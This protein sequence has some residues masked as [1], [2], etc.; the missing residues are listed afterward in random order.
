MKR[1]ILITL[2]FNSFLLFSQDRLP[3][4]VTYTYNVNNTNRLTDFTNKTNGQNIVSWHWDFGDGNS[5]N[6]PNPRHVY[7][8]EGIYLACLSITT[9]EGCENTFCD[10]IVIGLN[11][12]DTNSFYSISGNVFAGDNILPSG[13]ALLVNKVGTNYNVL[14]YTYISNGHYEFS[15]L[16]PGD[17]LIYAIPNFNVNVNYYPAYLPSYYGNSVKWQNASQIH[18]TTNSQNCNIQLVSNNAILYGPDTITGTINISDINSFEYNIYYSNWFGNIED[19]N[20]LKA[21]NMTVLLLDNNNIPLRFAITNENGDFI[22]T[23]LPVKIYRLVPEKPGYISS[24][25]LINLQTISS[26]SANCNFLMGTNSISIGIDGLE[27]SNI[28]N[29][30]PNPVTDYAIIS[31]SIEKPQEI[32]ISVL[33]L[34]GKEVMAKEY[35]NTHGNENYLIPFSSIRPGIYFVKIQGTE[36]PDI[37]RK[38]VKN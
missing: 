7:M 25:A 30:Y 23:N 3:C 21:A 26:N 34:E 22:F 13:I 10:T 14:Q 35:F 2:I 32:S 16:V 18:L 27:F 28:L 24:P 15:Q 36:M 33:S 6:L 11:P 4:V 8:N 31:L 9:A 19:V 12:N 1:I 17:Y 38:I 20:L 37:I 29:I 5:S